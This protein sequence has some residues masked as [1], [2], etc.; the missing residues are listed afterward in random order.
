MKT[1]IFTGA[2]TALVTPFT[3]NGVDFENFG[4]LIEMQIEQG[5]NALVICGTTGEASTMPDEE[6]ISVL[7]FAIEK[8]AKRV[9]VICGTGSNDTAHGIELC[10]EAEALGADALL[11][12]T[13][14]Y[15]KT[16]QEGLYQ[17]FKAM[18][19][20]VSIPM[21][22][23]NVP[24]RTGINIAPATVARLA[25]VENIVAVKECNLT[26]MADV[27]RLTPDDF[28]IYSGND[29]QIPYNLVMGGS[30]VI[31]VL[32]NVAPAYVVE[33]IQKFFNGDVAGCRKMQLDAIPLCNAL[34]SE[35][36]PIPAK[37]AVEMMGYCNGI[38]RMPLVPISEKNKE[39]LRAEMKAFGLID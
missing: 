5:I 1:K 14:Y 26:Q 24:T 29:D 8:V 36:N 31:S 28:S 16:T 23:Y 4:R 6:H 12:V 27:R 2:A 19:D 15:N 39:V 38:V 30:G 34:F 10:K 33:M 9:P 21:I 7:K 22:L 37:A 25:E 18:A 17:H 13:P 32:S 11:C 35:V 20:A 3:E